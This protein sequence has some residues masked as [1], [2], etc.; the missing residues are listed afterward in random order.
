MKQPV[1]HTILCLVSA[2]DIYGCR[3]LI[4]RIDKVDKATF[5]RSGRMGDKGIYQDWNA[6]VSPYCIWLLPGFD[7]Y[8]WYKTL[9]DAIGALQRRFQNNIYHGATFVDP[10]VYKREQAIAEQRYLESM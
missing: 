7:R 8:V 3:E 10:D 6:N 5:P 4:C 1:I 9:D 2:P